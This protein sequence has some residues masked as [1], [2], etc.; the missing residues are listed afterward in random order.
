MAGSRLPDGGG[1]SHHFRGNR[2][3]GPGRL[4]APA[5][6]QKKY[7]KFKKA[8]NSEPSAI[9]VTYTLRMGGI[10]NSPETS[11][12]VALSGRGAHG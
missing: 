7:R 5:A 4:P 9:A 2:N 8:G 1:E 6:P 11:V 10:Q 12:Y 3:P